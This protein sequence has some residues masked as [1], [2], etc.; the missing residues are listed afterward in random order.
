[1]AILMCVNWSAPLHECDCSQEKVF[2]FAKI[3]IPANVN[4]HWC[5]AVVDITE[6]ELRYYDPLG[7]GN[8]RC[9]EIITYTAIIIIITN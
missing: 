7:G 6:C 9:L 2:S 4:C 3:L 8:T 1:M 5:L